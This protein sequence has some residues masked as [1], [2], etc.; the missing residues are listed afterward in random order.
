[1]TP[2]R[3]KR[4]RRDVDVPARLHVDGRTL[5]ARLRD[6]CREAALVEADTPFDLGTQ[7]GLTLTLP[8]LSTPIELR[9]RVIRAAP[10]EVHA[11]AMAVLF[12]EVPAGDGTRIDFF[13]A[14]YDEQDEPAA[15]PPGGEGP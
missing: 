15:A 2:E 13:V 10:G 9:G 4:P 12:D 7:L 1:M 3:R 6:I 14:L 5:A 11:H 8:G